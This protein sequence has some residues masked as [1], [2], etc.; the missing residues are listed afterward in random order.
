[1]GVVYK[2]EDR[3]FQNRPVAVKEM[4]QHGLS[5]R[6]L[7]EAIE[8]FEREAYLLV[9]LSHPSLPKIHDHFEEGGRW[10]LVMDFIE[11]ENLEKYLEKAPGGRLPL[12]ETLKIGM[13]LSHVL[14]YLHSHRPPIIFR[15]LKPTNVM[16][17][18]TGE[19]YLIDFGIARLFKAGQA[20]DTVSYGSVGY[21]APEQFGKLTTPQSDIYSLGAL[22]HQLLSG[23]DPGA[24]TPNPF[25]FPPLS[26]VPAKLEGLVGQM[27]EMNATN[28]P[29]S[30]A[31]VYQ[32]LQGIEAQLVRK[33]PLPPTRST[34]TAA[35]V[36]KQRMLSPSQIPA[37]SQPSKKI[38]RRAV[39]IGMAALGLAVAGG[40]MELWVFAPHPL[41]T[42]GGH[43]ESVNA[44]T[45]SPDG[46][47]IASGS[48]DGTVQVWG[49]ENGNLVYTYPGHFQ[50]VDAVAWSPNGMYIASGGGDGTVQMW[51]ATDGNH[52]YTYR[53]HTARVNALAWSPD[54]TRIAW[55]SDDNTVQVYTADGNHVY[56]YRGH[57]ARVNA[58]GWSPDGTRI[59]SGS[60]DG[61]A[62][63]WDAEDG[64]HVFSYRGH[65]GY[66]VRAL[67]WSPTS[68]RIASGGADGTVQVWN[69]ADGNNVYT[70]RGH[71]QYVDINSVA[72]SPGGT[73]IVSGSD[74]GT[75]QVWDA[76]DGGHA[77][78]YHGHSD[79]YLGHAI[80]HAAVNSVT[81]SPGGTRI[82]SGS[83]DKTVQVW[84]DEG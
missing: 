58:L 67:A 39:I 26:R 45:W 28:R 47:R 31:A 53:G 61:T 78:M 83:S 11:G 54:G 8:S 52:V 30:M 13:K 36:S 7:I 40:G 22:L 50:S 49:A 76:A 16:R 1:M 41:Y 27:V 82:A 74:D 55:G 46:Y 66:A 77:Y 14:H 5:P 44:V 80:T 65:F 60:D 29:A 10:Y 34:P 9:D 15:D 69:V 48:A 2:A 6:E 4:N 19:I 71:T 37:R 73:R 20:Q 18:P 79:Y 35:A 56:T 12:K 32:E 23:Y 43:S 81:W 3:L 51:G 21:S 62:Q 24:N 17:T 70:Y 64:G 57:T 75:A 68:A 38:S 84:Q 25:T 72:W 63:A 42:Y 33:T 59:A